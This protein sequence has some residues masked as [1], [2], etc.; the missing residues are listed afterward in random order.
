MNLD[1]PNVSDEDIMIYLPQIGSGTYSDSDY[2]SRDGQFLDLHNTWTADQ[3]TAREDKA[4]CAIGFYSF[5]TLIDMKPK[6]GARYIHSASEPYNEEQELS[7]E[8]IDSWI[9][10]F[11]MV[12]FQSHCSGHARDKDLL[13]AVSQIGSKMIFPI[14]TENPEAYQRTISNITLVKESVKYS[15]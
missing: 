4:L 14:H 11:G 12:K 6:L 5:T 8:R 7:Q 2:N 9:D 1:I 10:H 15:L 13:E 3:I